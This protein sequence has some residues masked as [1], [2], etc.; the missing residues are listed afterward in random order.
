M[1]KH[2][3][4]WKLKESAEGKSRAENQQIFRDKLLD[5]VDKIPAVVSMEVGLKQAA[6]PENNDDVVLIAEY[7]TWAD[8]TTYNNH[9]DHQLVVEWVK[10]VVEKRSAVDY[11]Y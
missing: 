6:S 1:I 9:P 5:L 8:L 4:I 10:K 3:V 2:I 11:E 7:K